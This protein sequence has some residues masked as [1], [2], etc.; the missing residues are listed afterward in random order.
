MKAWN[1]HGS[2]LNKVGDLMMKCRLHGLHRVI[3]LVAALTLSSAPF[4]LNTQAHAQGIGGSFPEFGAN[5]GN[6][7]GRFVGTSAARLANGRFVLV[8]GLQASPLVDSGTYFQIY[9]SQGL[10]VG[11]LTRVKPMLMLEGA[12][13]ALAAATGDGFVVVWSYKNHFDSPARILGQRYSASG[14]KVGSELNINSTN[15]GF[16]W[17]QK[18]A[19]L[20]D[21]G[22]VVVWNGGPNASDSGEIYA[23]RY[24]G[25]GGKI[26]TEFIVNTARS[27]TQNFPA[28]AGLI[29]GGFVVA[30]ESAASDPYSDI[31]GQRYAANG[32]KV[33]A[34]M[35]IAGVSGKSETAPS[36]AGLHNGGFVVA[37]TGE[38]ADVYG[39][40]FNAAGVATT[41]AFTVGQRNYGHW[42]PLALTVLDDDRFVVAWGD[43]AFG[44]NL[45]ARLYG[46]AGAAASAE[47]NINAARPEFTNHLRPAGVA[48][49]NRKLFMVWEMTPS[50][51]SSEV[52]LR[53][54]DFPAR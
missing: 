5:T 42:E 52:R 17:Q 13:P 30:W 36:I 38:F 7:H 2:T 45:A 49:S 3:T 47:F 14:A 1:V 50:G 16:V 31:R 23:Q 34:E 28:V 12:S 32:S 24:D 54:L 37:W 48:L 27:K 8:M 4:A 33:G 41:A 53:R 39:R 19:G 21:G 22:F 29:D 44:D 26:G 35:T 10:A 25:K 43:G 15:P 51:K 6:L 40:Q 11:K 20:A 46:D 9:S 18:V